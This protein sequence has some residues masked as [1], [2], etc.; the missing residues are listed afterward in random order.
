MERSNRRTHVNLGLRLLVALTLMFSCAGLAPSITHA[1]TLAVCPSDCTY[2]SIQAAISAAASGDMI[3][4]GA[5]TYSELLTI[6]KN[7]TLQGAGAAHVTINGGGNGS[8]VTIGSGATVTIDGVTITGGNSTASFYRGG[9]GIINDGTLTV[10]NS[11]L[12]GN[13]ASGYGGGIANFGTLTVANSTL[14]GNSAYGG[15]GIDNDGTLTVTNSTFSGN[16]AD[17]G[18]GIYSVALVTVTNSTLS[19]N[20]AARSGGGIYNDGTLTVTNSTFSGNSAEGGGGIINHSTLAVTNSTLSGNSADSGNGGAIKSNL[21]T[22]TLSNTIVANSP[23]GGNCIGMA[24]DSG[25]NLSSDASCGFTAT[26]SQNSVDPLLDPNGLQSNGGPTQTIALLPGSPAIDAAVSCPPP[27][28][29]QRDVT[30]PQGP[31]CDSGAFEVVQNTPPATT[32][33]SDQASC[34]SAGGVY[35]SSL[36]WCSF[37]SYTVASCNTLVLVPS[38]TLSIVD[39]HDL[40]VNGTLQIE[41]PVTALVH[42]SFTNNGTIEIN[43]GALRIRFRDGGPATNNGV[44]NMNST[45]DALLI[46]N[47]VSFLNTGMINVRAGGSLINSNGTLTNNGTITLTCGS[48]FL[49]GNYSGAEPTGPGDCTG[50]TVTVNQ[51]QGQDDP[52]STGPINFTVVFGED[53]TGF[54]ADDVTLSGTAGAS[55]TVVTGGPA[56]YN[57][58]VDGMTQYGTVIASVR[59]DAVADAVGN[60]S[61]ASTSTDNTVT[62]SA[63]VSDSTPPAITITTEPSDILASTGWYSVASSGTDGV[64]VNVSASDGAGVTNITCV[65][66][67]TTTVLNTSSSSAFF[68]LGDGMHS[69]VCTATDGLGNT[70]AGS[71]STSMPVTY[72]VD[73][74]SPSVTV[75]R[76]SD[77]AG[78][79]T[80]SPINFTAAFSENVTSFEASDVS[81]SGTAG[82]TT[83]EVTGGPA[84]YGIAVSGMAANGTVIASV[85][86]GAAQDAAGNPS[87]ASSSTDNTVTYAGIDTTPPVVTPTVV[88]TLGN[89]GWYTSD[90]VVSWTVVDAES[91]VTSSPCPSTTITSDTIGQ[92]VSCNATST[93]GTSSNSV[94]IKRDATAPTLAPTVSPNPVLLNVTATATANAADALSGLASSSCD[95]VSTRSGGTQTVTCRATDQAGNNR[96]ANAAYTVITDTTAPTI[97]AQ[98]SG[99]L[100]NNGWYTSNVT[101]SWTV[102]DA[103]SAVTSQ[104]GCEATTVS[105]DTA[106]QTLTCEATSAG[107][108]GS[109]SV[110]IKRDATAPTLAPTVSPNP[111]L[112]NGSAAATPNAS[113]GRSGVASQSCGPIATS[114]VGSQSV[115]CTATDN[116]GNTST[117]PAAYTVTYAFSDFSSPV[118]AAPVLNS[119]KAGQ[120]IPLKWRITDANGVPVTNLASVQV[121]VASLSCSTGTGVDAVETYTTGASGLQNLGDGYYQYNWKT[122]KSYA[123]SCKTLRLD[124][125][126]GLYRTALF[127]F[128]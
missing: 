84:T 81:L 121:S 63:P 105:S 49:R 47:N 9:G 64:R 30:R 52:A 8:V 115:S 60:S 54:D 118:D 48:T 19:S 69:I 21:G 112:L 58:A 125:G 29:D 4:I 107:G 99:T 15:A 45:A 72:Q 85:P 93:G 33:I 101:V 7:L 50:P 88:G 108:T 79:T 73:Q 103:E 2:S 98:V 18:G 51:A 91:T 111:V 75:N 82:A 28:T 120:T 124:L 114:S 39:F 26:S 46:E 27:A 76:A 31:A 53:V 127:Q 59:A 3:T 20:S 104:S 95:P 55:S 24:G 122:P 83:K 25:G 62:Y 32:T 117:V 126:E 37:E 110:T 96:E 78:S 1:A 119:A 16:S 102:T 80:S 92:V 65:D 90:V 71:G 38:A 17:Y 6:D 128:K 43:E 13:S 68:I 86:A 40:T 100:G 66:N 10:T 14:S 109:A 42:R 94:T 22:T 116:A 41:G 23:S 89:N 77:Q 106:G 12:S 67:G 123:G 44:I 5:G 97:T 56:T 113:D 70:G 87:S 61:S 34:E 74:T 11:I 35:D 36:R 57:V